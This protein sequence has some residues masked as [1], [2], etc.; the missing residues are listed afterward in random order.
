MNK[1][2]NNFYKYLLAVILVISGLILYSQSLPVPID[3]PLVDMN[4]EAPGGKG[5]PQIKGKEH[6]YIQ[7]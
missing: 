4:I 2:Y 6:N 3:I 1:K 5:L 7:L